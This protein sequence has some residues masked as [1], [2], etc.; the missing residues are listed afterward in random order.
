MYICSMYLT[1]WN[2]DNFDIHMD[3]KYQTS[4]EKL[5][6]NEKLNQTKSS[7]KPIALFNNMYAGNSWSKIN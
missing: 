5:A 4:K 2:N 1:Y 7:L 6:T 3:V